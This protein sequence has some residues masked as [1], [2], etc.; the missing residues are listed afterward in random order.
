MTVDVRVITDSRNSLF[1][2]ASAGHMRLI[3]ARE[4]KTS[5]NDKWLANNGV[6]VTANFI[7]KIENRF[8]IKVID[9]F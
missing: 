1:I 7:E 9:L 5:M 6:D 2:P 8:L 3:A 4:W